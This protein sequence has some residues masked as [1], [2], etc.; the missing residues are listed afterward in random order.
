MRK[1]RYSQLKVGVQMT[2]FRES[3]SQTL[4]GSLQDGPE[5]VERHIDRLRAFSTSDTLG[6]LLWRLKYDNEKPERRDVITAIVKKMGYATNV[7]DA[8][9]H[10]W[11]SP[12]CK[13]C[14]G[15]I[16]MIA[17]DK[18][19]DCPR[20]ER[21]KGLHVYSD[22]DRANYMQVSRSEAERMRR[23]FR[24]LHDLFGTVDGG[25]NVNMNMELER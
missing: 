12:E 17:G 20:C 10:E 14:G 1:M 7:C 19:Y 18:R 6:T 23:K 11:L 4:R 22:K 8:A 24:N 5:G 25:V 3:I 16:T 13:L 9:L 15:R 2:N 21:H